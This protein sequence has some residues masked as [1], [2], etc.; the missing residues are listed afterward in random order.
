MSVQVNDILH[1]LVG[2]SASPST[3]GAQLDRLRFGIHTTPDPFRAREE[4]ES[5]LLQQAQLIRCIDS[6]AER[7]EFRINS[8]STPGGQTYKLLEKL[9]KA[10]K[11]GQGEIAL[12][13]LRAYHERC[14]SI[15]MSQE[16]GLLE[17]YNYLAS[18]ASSIVPAMPKGT[19]DPLQ[20]FRVGEAKRARNMAAEAYADS[21]LALQNHVRI[22]NKT[23]REF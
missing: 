14:T 19:T 22:F 21:L 2:R 6:F 5:H 11:R 8:P 18:I 23:Q 3:M 15:G 12:G 10:A 9:Q 1:F 4:V 13:T 17:V 7:D 20:A 16:R